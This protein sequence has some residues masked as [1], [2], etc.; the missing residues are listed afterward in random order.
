MARSKATSARRSGADG[1]SPGRQRERLDTDERR[2]RL[3]ASGQRVFA[4]RAYD[5]VSID[6]LAEAAGVSRG[7]FYHYF[8]TK[9]GFYVACLEAS[10][11][12]L[13]EQT[14]AAVDAAGNEPPARLR[15]GLNAYLS[16]VG[17]HGLTYAA[18]LRGGIGSDPEVATVIDETRAAFLDR[19]ITDENAPIQ[20][21][22]VPLLRLALRGW[23]GF[24]EAASLEWIRRPEIELAELRDYLIELFAVAVDGVLRRPR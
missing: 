5:E 22:S 12:H 23:V 16:Y 3:I 20:V 11:R 24:V 8:G 9:R 10:A 7:L 19:L 15:A 14:L 18:L 4:A 17:K 6:D 13:V 21:D 2:A 1:R